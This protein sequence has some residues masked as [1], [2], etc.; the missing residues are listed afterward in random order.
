VHNIQ[1]KTLQPQKM[2]LLKQIQRLNNTQQLWR[3]YWRHNPAVLEKF[4]I[5]KAS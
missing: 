2:E 1:K 3:E 4:G 5:Y